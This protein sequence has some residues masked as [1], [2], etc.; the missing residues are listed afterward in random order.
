MK[1]SLL[2]GISLLSVLSAAPQAQ[3]PEVRLRAAQQKETVEGDLQTAIK[4]YRA[5]A[6]DKTTPPDVAAQSLLRLG[7]CYERIRVEARKACERIVAQFAG[8]NAAVAEA[9]ASRSNAGERQ[10][11]RGRGRVGARKGSCEPWGQRNQPL[12]NG[13]S[14][15]ADAAVLRRGTTRRSS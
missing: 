12:A 6:D 11:C 5:L 2:V 4:T 8:Q 13:D 14:G 7:Q 1:C 15:L 3:G 9:N 10:Q